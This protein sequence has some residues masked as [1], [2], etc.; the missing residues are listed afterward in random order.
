MELEHV[1]LDMVNG[2]EKEKFIADCRRLGVHLTPDY[3]QA[4]GAY[5]R[6]LPRPEQ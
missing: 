2:E 4:V 5:R 3:Q 1:V 6:P